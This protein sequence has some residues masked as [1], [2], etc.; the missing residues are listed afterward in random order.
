MAKVKDSCRAETGR[1]ALKLEPLEQRMLLSGN[2]VVSVFHGDLLV[3]GDNAGNSIVLDQS[4]LATGQIRVTSGASV[5]T[6]NGAAGPTV[7][8]GVTKDVRFE[9]GGND[10]VELN[11][12]SVPRNLLFRDGKGTDTLT[13]DSSTI[14]GKMRIATKQGE[15]DYSDSASTVDRNLTIANR[16]GGSTVQLDSTSVGRRLW[17][18]EAKDTSA[19]SITLDGVHVDRRTHIHTGTAGDSVTVQDSSVFDKKFYLSTGLGDDV[20]TLMSSTF[21]GPLAVFMG[22]GN[23]TA[24]VGV[25]GPITVKKHAVFDGGSGTDTIDIKTNGNTFDHGDDIDGFETVT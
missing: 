24:D 10:T 6:I 4:G 23:D 25:G 3:K 8:S 19:D 2:V 18:K 15:L 7:F 12:V 11:S 1:V 14:A 9:M 21:D 20:A 16:R 22:G 5:T 13:T 17:I